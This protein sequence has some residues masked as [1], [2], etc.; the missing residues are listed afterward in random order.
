MPKKRPY[1][2]GDEIAIPLS[3]AWALGVI[4]R[5]NGKGLALGYFFGPIQRAIPAA[6][7]DLDPNVALYI[8]RFGDLGLIRG[9]WMVL[10]PTPNFT[11]DRWPVPLFGSRIE[12]RRGR[13]YR[14]RYDDQLREVARDVVPLAEIE[15][16]P[17]DGLAGSGFV[18]AKLAQL[19]G[20]Q[21]QV[22]ARAAT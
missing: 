21:R 14:V 16:L 7:I 18:E 13:G 5:A 22:D 12:L 8:R 4:A 1:T 15:G 20:Q 19:L 11:F 10:G 6:P 3:N 2:I 17:Q 9:D